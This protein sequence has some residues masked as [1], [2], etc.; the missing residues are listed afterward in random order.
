M[1]KE[2][3]TQSG[4]YLKVGDIVKKRHLVDGET[5]EYLNVLWLVLEVDEHPVHP[6][7]RLFPIANCENLPSRIIEK[8]AWHRGYFGSSTMNPESWINPVFIFDTV[9]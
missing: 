4:F 5:L 2:S 3:N 6:F 9:S 7:V 8:S 1:K